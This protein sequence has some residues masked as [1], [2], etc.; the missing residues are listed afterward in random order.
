MNDKLKRKGFTLIELLS[1]I[2][3]LSIL[4]VIVVPNIIKQVKVSKEKAFYISV[5]KMVENIKTDNIINNNDYCMYNYEDKNKENDF[6]K[7]YIL[8]TKENNDLIYSVYAS[9]NGIKTI[10]VKDFSKINEKDTSNWDKDMSNDS[11]YSSV[12][13]LYRNINL[14]EDNNYVVCD[15][16]E[17]RGDSND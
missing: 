14:I 2:V 7:L 15:L 5:S 12:S 3:I 1:V 6:D 9:K 10:N 13:K 16:K 11:A 4:I 8:V 17:S